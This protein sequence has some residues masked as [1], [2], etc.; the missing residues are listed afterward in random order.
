M[1]YQHSFDIWSI[2]VALLKHAQPG[3]HVYAGTRDNKGIFL[4]VKKSG[5]VVVAWQ[6]NARNHG[7]R[8]DYLQALRNY[9]KG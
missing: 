7:N 6:G 8:A 5:T 1:Q 2:P 3:Q 4:G 9:A